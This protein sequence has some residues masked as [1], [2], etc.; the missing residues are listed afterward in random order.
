MTIA[1]SLFAGD[2][3]AAKVTLLKKK[4]APPLIGRFLSRP[5]SQS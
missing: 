3:H 2:R 4:S 5:V 1:S